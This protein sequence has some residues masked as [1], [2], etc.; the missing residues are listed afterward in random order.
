MARTISISNPDKVLYPA[1]GFTKAQVVEYYRSVAPVLVP[2]LRGR[3]LTLRRFPDGVDGESFFE[4]RCPSH[5]PDWVTTVEVG[6]SS[7]PPYRACS[8]EDTDTVVWMANLAA[9][10]LHPSLSLAAE[11]ERPTTM[12]F[13]LDPGAPAGLAECAEVALALRALLSDLELESLA[14]TSGSKGMQVYVPLN[15]AVGYD[16]TKLLSHTIG[17]VIEKQLR[18]L[19]VTTMAKQD[20]PGKVFIDWSQN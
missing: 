1:T 15:T 18:P 4:K 10:E 17:L 6:R 9:L 20:R 16:T 19:V 7:G 5:A 14:K 12:V 8:V 11:P 13:D 2:H 3:A